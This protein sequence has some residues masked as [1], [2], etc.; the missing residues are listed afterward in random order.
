MTEKT[1]SEKLKEV[2]EFLEKI[3]LV[4]GIAHGSITVILE[5]PDSEMR[6]KLNDLWHKLTKDI[7][8]LYYNQPAIEPH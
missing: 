5:E 2:L 4:L 1:D 7:G 6:G 3:S 8:S